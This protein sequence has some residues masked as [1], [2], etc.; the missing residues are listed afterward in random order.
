MFLPLRLLIG[1]FRYPSAFPEQATTI[2]TVFAAWSNCL[3][4]FACYWF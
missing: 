4:G 3:E 2:R 1:L